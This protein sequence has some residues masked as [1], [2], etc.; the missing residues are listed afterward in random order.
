MKTAVIAGG[1]AFGA[2]T[3]GR[4]AALD[5]QYH[6]TVGC[7][8]G[9]LISTLAITRDWDRLI[10]AYTTCTQKDIFNVNPFKSNGKLKIIH[11]LKRLATGHL[12][13]GETYNLRKRIEYYFSKDIY[14]KIRSQGFEVIVTV[15]DISRYN[16][17]TEYKSI[18]ECGYREFCDFIWAST[19]V[20]I[21]CSIVPINGKQYVDGGLTEN[22]PYRYALQKCG[23]ELDIFV[24]RVEVHEPGPRKPIKNMLHHAG[25]LVK[26]TREEIE[27]NDIIT[28]EL[29]AA[30][31][32][33][34]SRTIYY[35]P[36]KL[37]ANS[38]IFDQKTMQG[39]V[40]EG[41]K[42]IENG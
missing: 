37:A 13:L 18:H 17:R 24:H 3:V 32:K 10:E 26:I 19:C 23:T 25:R 11:S 1:G 42:D 31:R 40:E 30:K 27:Y 9:S 12:T 41:I 5:K 6:M 22:I 21:A 16:A 28:G 38:L 8:T 4:L 2:F 35:L 39:W 7:S 15:K 14:D 36:R 20:P 33:D 29:E 34:I